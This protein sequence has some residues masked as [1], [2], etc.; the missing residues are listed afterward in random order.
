MPN[1]ATSRCRKTQMPKKSCR[2]P[3]LI[4]HMPNFCLN[5]L[6]WFKACPAFDPMVLDRW[7]PC[8]LVLSDLLR[9]RWLGCG[10]ALYAMAMSGCCWSGSMAY[11]PSEKSKPEERLESMKMPEERP[12]WSKQKNKMKERYQSALG[13]DGRRTEKGKEIGKALLLRCYWYSNGFKSWWWEREHDR[14]ALP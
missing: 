5:V 8:N 1:T 12:A 13:Q 4:I 10:P 6:E 7:R 14:W 3:S 9:C 11:L 2:P